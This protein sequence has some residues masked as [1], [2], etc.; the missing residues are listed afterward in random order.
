MGKPQGDLVPTDDSA[1]DSPER[2]DPSANHPGPRPISP[3]RPA[4]TSADSGTRFVAAV[5]AAAPAGFA[6]Y[7]G[8]REIIERWTVA[9]GQDFAVQLAAAAVSEV[10][11]HATA[12][13]ALMTAAISAWLGSRYGA[14]GDVVLRGCIAGLAAGVF[15][16]IVGAVLIGSELRSV[17]TIWTLATATVAVW[18]AVWSAREPDEQRMPISP[19]E[20][21]PEIHFASGGRNRPSR[22]SAISRNAVIIL[23][24]IAIG[25]SLILAGGYMYLELG[26]DYFPSEFTRPTIALIAL[27]SGSIMFLWIRIAD[28]VREGLVMLCAHFVAACASGAALACGIGFGIGNGLDPVGLAG[29]GASAA[30]ASALIALI[31]RG[32]LTRRATIWMFGPAIACGAAIYFV[33]GLLVLGDE[34]RLGP[35]TVPRYDTGQ[36]ARLAAAVVTSGITVWLIWATIRRNHRKFGIGITMACSMTGGIA[37]GLASS[38]IGTFHAPFIAATCNLGI[39]LL[40]VALGE[41]ILRWRSRLSKGS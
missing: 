10:A 31:L 5:A 8:T 16:L 27:I 39:F 7:F 34:I 33:V 2:T 1:E 38:D 23:L 30:L 19:M 22:V 32:Y 6:V 29:S 14:L 13:V 40:A 28:P 25:S 3:L 4:G 36:V 21:S 18:L 24:T 15:S 20:T 17:L 41:A 9:T 26:F 12:L 35:L 11:S 37:A